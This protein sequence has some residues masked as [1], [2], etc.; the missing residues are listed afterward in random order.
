MLPST[1]ALM[2][3]PLKTLPVYVS[4]SLC[5]PPA[6]LDHGETVDPRWLCADQRTEKST[7]VYDG[8]PCN[9]KEQKKKNKTEK[10]R[11]KK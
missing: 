10:K 4:P 6:I 8:V 11:V 9:R 3:K 2:L 1:F 7:F 5:S